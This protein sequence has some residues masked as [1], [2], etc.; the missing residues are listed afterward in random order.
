MTYLCQ[1]MKLF[2]FQHGFKHKMMYLEQIKISFYNG[3]TLSELGH[4]ATIAK[5]N[6]TLPSRI[7]QN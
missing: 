4:H 1:I 6:G 7:S 2:R 3:V 5:Y